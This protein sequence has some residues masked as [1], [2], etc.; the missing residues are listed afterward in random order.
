MRHRHIPILLAVALLALLTGTAAALAKTSPLSA[1]VSIAPQGPSSPDYVGSGR[2]PGFYTINTRPDIDLSDPKYGVVGDI[3]YFKWAQSNPAENVYNFGDID[4]FITT[5]AT[6][7]RKVGLSFVT[8]T[9]RWETTPGVICAADAMP[10]WARK[11]HPGGS[12][13]INNYTIKVASPKPPDPNRPGFRLDLPCEAPIYWSTLY[14]TYLRKWVHALAQHLF[15]ERPDLGA[16]VEFIGMAHG[17]DGETRPVDNED[18]PD[19][20][21]LPGGFTSAIWV[22]AVNAITDIW[23]DEFRNQAGFTGPLFILGSPYYK[24]CT[25]RPQFLG[26]AANRGVGIAI[27]GLYPDSN[28]AVFGTIG[29]PPNCGAHDGIVN[30]GH[31]VPVAWETYQHMLR[32]N[33]DFYW[34]TLHALG[35][36]S[37]YIRIRRQFVY[38]DAN[39]QPVPEIVSII[40]QWQPYFGVTVDNTPSIWVAMREHRNPMEYGSQGFETNSNWPVLGNFEFYLRQVDSVPNGRT[41]IE[42]NTSTVRGQAVSLGLCGPAPIGPPGYGCNNSPYNSQLPPSNE[43]RSVGGNV[44]LSNIEAYFARRTDQATNNY[45]MW[46]D[47]DGGYINPGGIP[48]GPRQVRITVKYFDISNDRWRLLYDSVSGPKYATLDGTGQT[49]VQKQGNRVLRT[50]V[51]TIDDA[52]LNG[53]LTGGMDFAIDSRNENGV[54]DG[55]EWI[56]M[57]DVVRISFSTPTPTPTYTPTETPTET[58]TATPTP[59]ATSGLGRVHGMV[60]HDISGDGLRQE[61]EPGVAGAVVSAFTFPAN[62]EVMSQ[63]TASD[64]LYAFS[65]SPGTYRI[66]K[67]NPPGYTTNPEHDVPFVAPLSGG[68]DWEWNFP[69][70]AFTPTPTPTATPSPTPTRMHGYLP[71]VLRNA[72]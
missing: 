14:Q 67:T 40:Q 10:D 23:W 63:T 53:H 7:G 50:A 34:A 36:H 18:E 49:W 60:F 61:G 28:G 58:P 39:G 48:E 25:E 12:A 68:S 6:G 11:P 55:D 16:K 27:L 57:V 5:K 62:T 54:S 45:M 64:G 24:S 21:S 59:T 56:H 69:V 1:P 9:T 30:Y 66:T 37:D 8:T 4:Y 35:R 52:R 43:L 51:F 13:N 70:I 31:R 72:P 32:Y 29:N 44:I 38:Q 26:W 33:R 41:V 22:S 2:R 65:L 46:F 17:V 15:V 42:T 3:G 20:E 19:L 71:M 47:A